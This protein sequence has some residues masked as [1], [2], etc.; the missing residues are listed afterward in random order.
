LGNSADAEDTLQEV[1]FALHQGLPRFRGEAQLSTWAYRIA[2]RAALHKKARARN[3]AEESLESD[4]PNVG[5]GVQDKELARA[6]D[7]SV[8]SL[9]PEYRAV[10][11]LCCIEELSRKDVARI[12]GLPEGTVW[13][14]LHRARKDALEM[15]A[16]M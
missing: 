6:L 11:S 9:R 13:T 15:R 14:R 5:D 1:F 16:W 12:L 4:P 10:F 2:V 7:R 8:A 3:R